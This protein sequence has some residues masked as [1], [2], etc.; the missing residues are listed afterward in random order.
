[1][2]QFFMV[3]PSNSSMDLYP[4]NKVSN[5][6]VNLPNALN[7]NASKWEVGLSEIQFQHTWYN[8]REGKNT[9]IKELWNPTVSELNQ[10]FPIKEGSNT[11][12]ETK[13]REEALSRKPN[14]VSLKY[15]VD[16]TIPPGY[17]TS[18]EDILSKIEKHDHTQSLRRID[19]KYDA[20]SRRTNIS[21]PKSCKLNMNG[22]DIERCL[23]FQKNTVLDIENNTSFS[24]ASTENTYKSIYVYLDIIKNQYVGSVKVPLL[25]AVPVTSKYGDVSCIKYDKPHFVALS[26]SNIQ[27]IEIDLRDDTGEFVSFEAGRAIVTLVFRRIVAKFFD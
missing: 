25:R 1:M 13:K 17:Y 23:G 15:Q 16:I 27:T 22:S 21:L 6:K 5:F 20:L 9:I 4:D 7:L 14:D 26:R 11:E 3:L 19:Y 24:I 2:N 10:L 8:V 12:E 18:V